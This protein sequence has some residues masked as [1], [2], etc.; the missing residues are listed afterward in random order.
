M[1]SLQ[2]SSPLSKIQRSLTFFVSGQAQHGFKGFPSV[3]MGNSPECVRVVF[4]GCA[5]VTNQLE[6]ML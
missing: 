5:M 6:K 3:P 1:Y 4:T 2:F